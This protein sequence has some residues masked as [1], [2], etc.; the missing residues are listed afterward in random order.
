MTIDTVHDESGELCSSRPGHFL[1]LP[2]EIRLQVYAAVIGRVNLSLKKQPRPF[3]GSEARS[4]KPSHKYKIRHPALKLLLICKQVNSEVRQRLCPSIPLDLSQHTTALQSNVWQVAFL[5]SLIN[6]MPKIIC[7]VKSAQELFEH[8]RSFRVGEGWFSCHHLRELIILDSSPLLFAL[9]QPESHAWRLLF[10][11]PDDV[12]YTTASKLITRS[13]RRFR[14]ESLKIVLK[15]FK[16]RGTT[17][18]IRSPRLV[19]I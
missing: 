16:A 6:S 5:T 19:S 9:T 3:A 8:H 2:T 4:G 1:D 18:K 7:S 14:L 17:I 11:E 15:S 13:K 10:S 12:F